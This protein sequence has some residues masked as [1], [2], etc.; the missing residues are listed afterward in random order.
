MD[1]WGQLLGKMHPAVVHFP[2]VLLLMA[3][4]CEGLHLILKKSFFHHAAELNLGLSIFALTISIICGWI[5]AATTHDIPIDAKHLLPWH[6]YLGVAV[7]LTDM[8]AFACLH[9]SRY[10]RDRWKIA[11]WLFLTLSGFLVAITGHL[12]G[13]LVY[14]V[15]YFN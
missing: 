12:G 8:A 14:G 5:L 7:L 9:L 13:K 10:H 4:L 11:Y 2:I 3:C 15:D 1:S 6:R